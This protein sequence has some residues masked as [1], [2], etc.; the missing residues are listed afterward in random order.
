MLINL[1]I[2][3]KKFLL[4][5]GNVLAIDLLKDIKIR[6]NKIEFDK[7]NNKIFSEGKTY[8]NINEKYKIESKNVDYKISEAVISSK[9][10][11]K[12]Q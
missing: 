10:I 5:E 11:T 12:N 2:I 7:L 6:S 8:F 3:K 4:A 1:F 9:E